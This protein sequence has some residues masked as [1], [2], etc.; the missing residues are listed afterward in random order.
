MKRILCLLL[1]ALLNLVLSV[2][3]TV[4]DPIF[5]GMEKDELFPSVIADGALPRKT[6]SM[7]DARDKRYYMECRKVK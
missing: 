2:I 6:F 1:M 5:G 4:I 3:L 7:G